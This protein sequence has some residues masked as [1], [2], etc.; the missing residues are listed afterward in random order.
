MQTPEEKIALITEVADKLY[1]A[2]NTFEGEVGLQLSYLYPAIA[3][4]GDV[5]WLEAFEDMGELND[6]AI[7]ELFRSLFPS[8]HAIWQYI[9]IIPDYVGEHFS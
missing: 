8:E 5:D 9:R 3:K 6:K 7:I 4:G 1:D 2:T